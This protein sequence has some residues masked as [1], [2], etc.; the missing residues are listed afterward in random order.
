M[1][2]EELIQAGAAAAKAG[3]FARATSLFASAVREDPNSER[4][5]L[6]LGLCCPDLRQREYCFRRVL[7]I[8]PNNL[9]ARQ[10]LERLDNLTTAPLTATPPP[11]PIPKAPPLEPRSAP[12]RTTS[13]MQAILSASEEVPEWARDTRE[14]PA[15]LARTAPS[16]AAP[17]PKK[18][19]RAAPVLI[20]FGLVSLVCVG[21]IAFLY[22]SGRLANWLPANM[23]FPGGLFAVTETPTRPRPTITNTPL[24]PSP[25][26][27]PTQKPTIVYT[28][29][30]E[31]EPCTFTRVEGVV[32]NCGYVTV[33]EDRTDEKTRDI[34]LAVVVFHATGE[35]PA[36]DPVMFL[37]GGPGGEAVELSARAYK[38]LVKPFLANRDYIAFDQRGTGLSEP[39]LGC[40]ELTTVYTQDIHGYISPSSRNLVYTNAFRS[41]HGMMSVSGIDLNAYNT[42][43]SAADL[44]DILAVLGYDQVNLYGASYGTRLAQVVMRDYPEI[45]RSAILDSVV[46]IE[47][48]LYNEDVLRYREALQN[49]FDSCAAD[50]ACDAAYPDLETT[51]WNLVDQLDAQPV[52]VT[53]PLMTGGEITET[54]NGSTLV[55]VTLATLKQSIF[56]PT[57]PQTI[58]RTERGDY[59]TIIAAQSALPFA[60]EGIDI[61][62][63]IS[64]M[65]REHILATTPDELQN[66]MAAHHD[67]GDYSRLPFYGG[68]EDLFKICRLWGASSPYLGENDPLSSDI[69][70]LVIAGKFDP[71]TPPVFGR[72]VAERLSRSLYVEFPNQGHVPTASDSSGCAM[73][74]ATDFLNEPDYGP[75]LSCVE[76]LNSVDFI[77]PYTGDP[78]VKLQTIQ[79]YGFKAK[80]P[81]DWYELWTGIYLRDNSP[82]D[83]T[84]LLVTQTYFA[85]TDDL[86]ESLSSKLYAYQGFDAAP[87]QIGVRQANGLNW[88]M[89]MTSSYGRP[90]E[91][92]MADDPHWGAYVVLLFCHKDERDAL[93]DT[94]F[95]PVIDSLVPTR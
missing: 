58:H 56:I 86:L 90:V 24:P 53:A 68:A 52:S 76:E 46:P 91:L 32:V 22:L 49:L 88:S 44:K 11:P 34:R 94:V 43:A 45:V 74:I 35:D 15:G 31:N 2:S 12:E 25:T 55:G 37:Q 70:T 29:V 82:L 78:P 23:A 71:T 21:A 80:M 67:L 60:F 69:P 26:P 5:W 75:D 41:C 61:G 89:Y 40:D 85:N 20:S 66:A 81:T 72:Q 92:A 28:P 36:P 50:P 1:S 9:Q 47:T 42:A 84:Q 3:D 64:V 57:V 30:F 16:A 17:Q 87:V 10:Q 39:A 27:I 63:Y 62:L 38:I 95:L 83:I 54:V 7:A 93:Y 4:G 8:N 14:S 48:R 73:K 19:N 79:G 65:C 18:K 59:S 6:G 77:L 51:F 33:P 13:R